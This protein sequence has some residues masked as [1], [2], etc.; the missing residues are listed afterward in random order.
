MMNKL[1]LVKANIIEH[2]A[3][4]KQN[5]LAQDYHQHDVTMAFF[6]H[7]ISPKSQV[8]NFKFS[9]VKLFFEDKVNNEWRLVPNS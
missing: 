3:I 9:K 1:T 2:Y 7:D 4:T 5:N 6:I 8:Q